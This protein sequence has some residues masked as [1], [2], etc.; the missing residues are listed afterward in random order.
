L[1]FNGQLNIC[2]DFRHSHFAEPEQITPPQAA[3]GAR[4]D[5]ILVAKMI[6]SI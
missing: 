1:P 4:L 3:T 6:P 2:S 5:A